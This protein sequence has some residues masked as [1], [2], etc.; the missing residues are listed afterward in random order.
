[1]VLIAPHPRPLPT[2][3]KGSR[4]EG[5]GEAV[6]TS[7]DQQQAMERYVSAYTRKRGPRLGN[8]RMH[9]ALKTRVNALMAPG[10]PLPR[11]RTEYDATLSENAVAP[12][13]QRMRQ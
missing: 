8:V 9:S 1:M 6:L 4:G 7:R 13:A 3:R 10:S 5:S 12:V 2:A 11:G